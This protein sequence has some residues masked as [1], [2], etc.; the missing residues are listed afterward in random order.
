[1]TARRSCG[2]YIDERGR[3]CNCVEHWRQRLKPLK[4][5]YDLV[6]HDERK[7]DRRAVRQSLAY[8]ETEPH[9]D[10]R[11]AFRAVERGAA[12][13][14]RLMAGETRAVWRAQY[15][16]WW[17]AL[18]KHAQRGLTACRGH[19]RLAARESAWVDLIKELGA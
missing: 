18:A 10:E 6:A 2:C 16:A 9:F 11:R 3:T 15:V 17:R 14:G 12:R 19:A 1:M 7:Y 8:L 4:R 5:R 13:L